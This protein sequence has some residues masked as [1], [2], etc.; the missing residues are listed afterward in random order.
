[1]KAGSAIRVKGPVSEQVVNQAMAKVAN[2]TAD[3]R[4]VTIQQQA[5]ALSEITNEIYSLLYAK[6]SELIDVEQMLQPEEVSDV[7]CPVSNC[8]T[9]RIIDINRRS[10]KNCDDINRILG[11][12]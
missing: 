7:P 5:N 2:A 6:L 12:L 4:F 8:W 11:L 3:E 9:D 1:M 10:I